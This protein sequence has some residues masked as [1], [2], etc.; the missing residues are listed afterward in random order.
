MRD[1]TGTLIGSLNGNFDRKCNG[2][3]DH[4]FN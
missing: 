4:K 1:L 3:L 2:T